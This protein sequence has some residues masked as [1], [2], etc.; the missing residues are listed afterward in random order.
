M[1]SARSSALVRVPAES[2]ET[3]T[4][5][6]EK[7]E[8]GKTSQRKERVKKAG[9]T[10]AQVSGID[11][12]WEI[13]P[14]PV[15]KITP[16]WA[17]ELRSQLETGH[18]AGGEKILHDNFREGGG[19]GKTGLGRKPGSL[20]PG[21]PQDC[22]GGFCFSWLC[23]HH[24]FGCPG[25]WE[26][27]AG[28]IT[29]GRRSWAS[30]AFTL[31]YFYRYIPLYPSIYHQTWSC[32]TLWTR[33]SVSHSSPPG[34]SNLFH[35]YNRNRKVFPEGKA[36]EAP[37]PGSPGAEWADLAG[38]IQVAGDPPAGATAMN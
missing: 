3:V 33:S 15:P 10:E 36:P 8:W 9:C 38:N 6:Q 1:S 18:R 37:C 35:Q 25:K 31:R 14:F 16:P 21:F 27:A 11:S 13:S 29:L 30:Q 20:L 19:N 12:C 24:P 26:A 4:W 28:E 32:L 5:L 2:S 23:I 34:D 22:P 17:P 7:R